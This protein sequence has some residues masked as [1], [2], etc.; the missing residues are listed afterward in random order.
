V[1]ENGVWDTVSDDFTVLLLV[2]VRVGYKLAA[3]PANPPPLL[4]VELFD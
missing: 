4:L 2:I 1:D 3:I